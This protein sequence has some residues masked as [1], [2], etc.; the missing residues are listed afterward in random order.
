MTRNEFVEFAVR[1]GWVADRFRHYQKVRK[2]KRYRLKMGE[3][4]VRY[5]VR[6]SS[7]DAARWVLLASN[8]YSRLKVETVGGTERL[9]G[10]VLGKR[11]GE[12]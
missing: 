10:L 3:R 8:Y 6:I 12:A 7:G 5:E 2:D 11:T 4:S 9:A 1:G